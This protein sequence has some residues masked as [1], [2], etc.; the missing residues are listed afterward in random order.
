[1][2]GAHAVLTRIAGEGRVEVTYPRS[3]GWWLASRRTKTAV[4]NRALADAGIYAS[5]LEGGSDSSPSSCN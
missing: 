5:G 1:V 4:V 3:H 2:V